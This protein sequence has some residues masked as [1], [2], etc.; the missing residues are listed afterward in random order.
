MNQV[1]PK[2]IIRLALE[3]KCLTY[4][5]GRIPAAFLQNMPFRKVM[6]MLDGLKEYQKKE[7][8]KI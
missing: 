6:S 8:V 3:G 5:S 1:T 2:D 4:K 7:Q